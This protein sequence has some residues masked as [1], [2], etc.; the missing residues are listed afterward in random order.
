M[1]DTDAEVIWN[2]KVY[3]AEEGVLEIALP[4]DETQSVALVFRNK[5]FE[6][7]SFAVEIRDVVGSKSNPIV[8][9]SIA[10]VQAELAE[11]D[12]DGV[13]YSWTADRSGILK[14]T[15][16]N[17]AGTDAADAVITVK[18]TSVRLSEG[19]GMAQLPV[20]EGE[21]VILQ[22]LT[23]EDTYPQARI[24]I[25]GYVAVM[26]DMEISQIPSQV[27]SVTVD[28]GQSVILRIT[29]R[30]RKSLKIADS[31]FA[32][33]YDGVT[34]TP[35]AQGV[36][37]MN[38][39][40]GTA[41]LELINQGTEPKTTQLFFDYPMGHEQNPH[42]LTGLGQLAVSIPEDQEGYWYS[43]TA[44]IPGMVTF[45]IWTYP[46]MENVKTDIV[47]TNQTTGESNA[48]WSEDELENPT[49]SMLVNT[50]DELTVWVSVT[51][52][53][54][55]SVFTDLEI[56][57][58]LYG[59]EELPILVEHPGFT[60]YVPAGATL[61]YE[62][63]NLAEML[64]TL[65]GTAFTVSHNGT[66]YTPNDGRMTF[67]IVVEGRNPARFAITNTGSQMAAFT[68][69]FAYPVGHAQNPAALVLG[70]NTVTR[71]AGASDFYY[72]FTA[73]KAGTLTFTF[74][75]SAQ[76]VYTVDNLTQELYGDTQWSDS[77]P[78][79]NVMTLKVNAKDQIQIR[80]N[81]YDAA[82]M[83]ESP[84]G[85]VV[86]ET[87]Y[88][89]GPTTIK[90]LEVTTYTTLI[91][92]EGGAYNGNLYGMIL[93]VS[94]AQNAA[95]EYD[96]V[97][98]T[99]DA[100]GNITVK[101]QDSGTGDLQYIIYNTGVSQSV[102]KMQFNSS[103]LGSMANPEIISTGSYSMVQDK[104]G[105][106]V[107]YYEFVAEEAGYLVITFETDVNALYLINNNILRYTHM[108][109]NTYR[110][111]VRKGQVVSLVVNTHNPNNYQL[112]PVGTVDF[113]IE[114][115]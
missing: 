92:G 41:E 31:D 3:Q 15:L 102:M 36:I 42:S 39:P 78:L 112:N 47:I 90:N 69:T 57:G 91:A 93:K 104:V 35:D 34:Y 113:T 49:V 44:P 88:I 50:G 16:G 71:T 14:M 28:A 63:Y 5:N 72:T 79:M 99:A 83:S 24:Q 110:M 32:V 48:L 46:E 33:M 30:N 18:G 80:V 26:V 29:G 45:Q 74:D 64:L 22:V 76:W 38:L 84:A 6:E 107:Y 53:F 97:I 61:Y 13:Y 51:D 65:E 77:D 21:E 103:E 10:D 67:P 7:K 111:S 101:F 62:G 114:M 81:T 37:Q 23:Q 12:A 4:A 94:D 85:S 59:T 20:K 40:D 100:T 1:E 8:L 60:A 82:N 58:E 25:G 95:V 89:S 11:G 43:Y 75:P 55:Y 106:P 86:F 68:G 108:G 27:E 17:V 73:P 66:D 52:I 56:S 9:D 19:G 2:E 98:Y 109:Q 96:G 87:K 115:Q 54:G 70:T 105:G